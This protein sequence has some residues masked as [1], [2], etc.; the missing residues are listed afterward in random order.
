VSYEFSDVIGAEVVGEGG[1][2]VRA[3]ARAPA[4]RRRRESWKRRRLEEG[5]ASRVERP[6][7]LGVG[8][9]DYV[10]CLS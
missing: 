8:N 1:S 4:S 10:Y 7:P 3:E 9:K 5:A 2:C 6:T